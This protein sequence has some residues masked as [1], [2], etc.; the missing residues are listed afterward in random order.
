MKDE[1]HEM[2]RVGMGLIII[3]AFVGALVIYAIW[4]ALP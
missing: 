4:S 2:R 3:S 1:E